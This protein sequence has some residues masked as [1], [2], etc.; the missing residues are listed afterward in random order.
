MEPS[1]TWIVF[2]LKNT[3]KYFFGIYLT[4]EFIIPFIKT[5]GSVTIFNNRGI[6]TFYTTFQQTFP[7]RSTINSKVTFPFY[8]QFL[9]LTLHR[10][11]Y[12]L[13]QQIISVNIMHFFLKFTVSGIFIRAKKPPNWDNSTVN[14]CSDKMIFSPL[15][16]LTL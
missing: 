2:S 7:D 11:Y 13:I 16:I 5:F 4:N 9:L 15:H 6:A 14:P 3:I 8:T 10:I 1:E 12:T